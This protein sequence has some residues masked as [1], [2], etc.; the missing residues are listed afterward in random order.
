[1]DSIIS[2]YTRFTCTYMISRLHFF[3]H[4]FLLLL[5]PS[6]LVLFYFRVP[7]INCKHRCYNANVPI[8]KGPVRPCLLPDIGQYH[9][10]MTNVMLTRPSPK[11]R[12]MPRPIKRKPP[13][14]S[15][16]HS[17]RRLVTRKKRL[18]K[19]KGP[20]SLFALSLALPP[21]YCTR[22]HKQRESLPDFAS[23]PLVHFR[24]PFR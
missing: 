14:T 15:F 17:R 19:T 11:P 8:P 18:A 24:F 1:M 21:S 22:R 7:K 5:M 2:A 20:A 3:F 10:I 13:K 6:G 9:T 16:I 23:P 12:P 4:F